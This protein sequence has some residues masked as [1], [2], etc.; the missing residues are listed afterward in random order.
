MVRTVVAQSPMARRVVVR[1]VIVPCTVR[2]GDPQVEPGPSWVDRPAEKLRRPGGD[3]VPPVAHM[4]PALAEHL[5]RRGEQGPGR[6]LRG[7]GGRGGHRVVHDAGGRQH[8]GGTDG[9]AH[10]QTWRP[11][12]LAHRPEHD[13]CIDPGDVV[14]RGRCLV[15]PQLA[16]HLVADQEHTLARAGLGDLGE[17]GGGRHTPGRV[18]RVAQDDERGV[19]V[20]GQRLDERVGVE[21]AAGG[22][23]VA[24]RVR[25]AQAGEGDVG[26]ETGV[27]HEDGGAGLDVGLVEREERGLAARRDHDLLGSHGCSGPTGRA[28]L[29]G[30]ARARGVVGGDGLDEVGAAGVRA[31]GQGALVGAGVGQGGPGGLRQRPAWLTQ[32]EADRPGWCAQGHA[33]D[34]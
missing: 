27:R 20:G 14:Q 6:P 13:P 3:Q 11:E 21:V 12:G 10:P 9:P 16:V 26:D 19:R 30:L 5:V 33:A 4:L 8:L 2:H 25:T 15:H 7:L 17:G 28:S 34:G 22:Q 24:D 32:P 1:G 18:G 29:P 31:V 23:G